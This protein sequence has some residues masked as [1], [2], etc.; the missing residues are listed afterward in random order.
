MRTCEC[1]HEIRLPHFPSPPPPQR[2]RPSGRPTRQLARLQVKLDPIRTT[3]TTRKRKKKT[4][5]TKTKKIYEGK[6]DKETTKTK[7]IKKD[8]EDKDTEKEKE[9]EKKS[10]IRGISDSC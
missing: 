8:K 5:K 4:R 6:E 7:T 1:H 2:A 10:F 9:K 3:T